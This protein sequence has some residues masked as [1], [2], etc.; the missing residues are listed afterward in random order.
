LNNKEKDVATLDMANTILT[1]GLTVRETAKM[2]KTSKS[3]VWLYMTTRLPSLNPE[4]A[5]QIDK[6]F[7]KHLA[8]RHINGGNATKKMYENK[9]T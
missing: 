3:T 9:S 5:E 2:F 1:H 8:V 4:L 7:K 6:I